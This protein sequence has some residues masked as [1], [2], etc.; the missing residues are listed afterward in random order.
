MKHTANAIKWKHKITTKMLIPDNN[1]ETIMKDHT[2][3][4]NG[5]LNFYKR[6]VT[7]VPSSAVSTT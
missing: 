1:Y 7:V 6:D 3:I 2:F 4:H 5:V